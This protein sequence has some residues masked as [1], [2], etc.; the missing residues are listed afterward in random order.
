M[1]N[2]PQVGLDLCAHVLFGGI[3][4]GRN[5]GITGIVNYH[6]EPPK[7][8]NGY[9]YSGTGLPRFR[10]VKLNNAHV[11]F[12]ALYQ[13]VQLFGLASGGNQQVAMSQHCFG[14]TAP[15]AAR[16]ASNQPDFLL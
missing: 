1:N 2:T 12:I 3:L 4:N 16:T 11:L 15:K 9:G 8:I 14:E 10:H 13:I 6:V 5:V 7:A